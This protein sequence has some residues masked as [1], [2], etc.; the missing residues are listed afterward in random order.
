MNKNAEV[1]NY[2]YQ[3]S[4]MGVETLEQIIPM[5]ESEEF[6]QVIDSQLNEYKKINKK[7]KNLLSQNG[8]DEKGIGDLERITTYFMISMQTITNKSKSHL[9]DMIIK[10][11][12]MGI[13]EGTKKLH[14]YEDAADR[15]V[16][17]LMK[18]LVKMEEHNLEELKKYL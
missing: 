17:G 6:K 18:E 13:V 8:C 3:N 2:V 4:Q 14:E 7:A 1:L 5:I 12:N 11:S 10:G 16:L 9:A 15:E